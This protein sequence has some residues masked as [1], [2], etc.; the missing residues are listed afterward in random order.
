MIRADKTLKGNSLDFMNSSLLLKK[1][2]KVSRHFRTSE[3]AL[4]LT[5]GRFRVLARLRIIVSSSG[6]SAGRGSE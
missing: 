3:T 6:S 2:V 5:T 1:A 4:L